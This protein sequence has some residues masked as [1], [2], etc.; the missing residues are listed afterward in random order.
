MK[1]ILEESVQGVVFAA[2]D[3]ARKKKSS[4]IR[5]KEP[6]STTK[7]KKTLQA[8]SRILRTQIDQIAETSLNLKLSCLIKK[9]SKKLKLKSSKSYLSPK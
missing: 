4:K 9:S 7:K 2:S 5:L 3:A 6:R 8:K 1:G